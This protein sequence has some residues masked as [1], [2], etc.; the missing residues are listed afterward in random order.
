MVKIDWK[1]YF[2]QRIWFGW[3]HRGWYDEDDIW[4]M[5]WCRDPNPVYH[6]GIYMMSAGSAGRNKEELKYWEWTTKYE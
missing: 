3:W 5:D 6:W 1:L 4:K 2:R